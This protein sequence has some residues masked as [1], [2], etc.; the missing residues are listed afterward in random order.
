M[1]VLFIGDIFARPGRTLVKNCL[2]EIKEQYQIEFCI[3]NGENAAGGK[4][5]T[6]KVANELYSAGIDVITL[7]NHTWDNKDVFTFIDDDANLIRPLNFNPTLPGKGYTTLSIRHGIKITVVQLCCRVFMMQVDCPFRK[8]DDF[9]QQTDTDA[10]IIVDLHGEATSE[11]MA[12]G[13][14]LDGRVSAIIGTHTH[15]PTADERILPHGSAYITDVGMTGPYDS[16]I[17]MEIEPITHQFLT[18][19][20]ASFK[21]AKDNVKLSAVV[22]SFNEST[23]KATSI[24]RI[25]IQ[26]ENQAF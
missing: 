20:R 5:I 22:V 2:P 8:I 17:G 25:M 26:K 15:V 7:G 19:I 16:V 23:K 24:R 9:L 3:A 11:K 14:Y 12:M 13:W 1:N 18:S 4:G 21:V 6:Q 10:I